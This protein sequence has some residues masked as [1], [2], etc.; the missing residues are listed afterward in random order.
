MVVCVVVIV[1]VFVVDRRGSLPHLYLFDKTLE[2][3]LGEGDRLL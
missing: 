3:T 2:T 1:V